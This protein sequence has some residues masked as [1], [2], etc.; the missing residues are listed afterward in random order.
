MARLKKLVQNARDVRSV[1]PHTSSPLIAL[2]NVT[3][4]CNY[5]CGY[6]VGSYYADRDMMDLDQIRE[7]LTGLRRL[8]VKLLGLAGGEPLLHRDIDGVIEIAKD[9]GFVVGLNTNGTLVSRHLE[10]LKRLDSLTFSID[11]S[12]E[13]NDQMRGK[14]AYKDAINGMKL[15]AEAGISLQ[16]NTVLTRDNIDELEAVLKLGQEYKAPVSI[17]PVFEN[18]VGQEREGVD[19]LHGDPLAPVLE[20]IIRLKEQG[21]PVRFS[22]KT[23]ERVANWPDPAVDKLPERV[24]GYPRCVAGQKYIFISAM[25]VMYPCALHSQPPMGQDCLKMGVEEAYRALERPQCESCRWPCMIE[26][27]SMC[28]WELD[29]FRSQFTNFLQYRLPHMLQSSAWVAAA[30]AK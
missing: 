3:E 23:Y 17:S 2:Y 30:S 20:K 18:V 21:Y 4:W 1:L 28:T 14:G 26:F 25:G 6:C 5:R 29:A 16:I 22:K 11:A 19:E 8:G 9:L 24:E 7:V 12:A 27:H 13:V 15:A 10:A